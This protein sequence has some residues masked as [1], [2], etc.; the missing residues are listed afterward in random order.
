VSDS[1]D[2]LFM[3][4]CL[5]LARK[6]AGRTSPNPMVGCVIARDGAAVAAGLHTAFGKPHA[7]VVALESAGPAARGATLYTNLEPCTHTGQTPP[8]TDAIQRAGIAKV[9]FGSRDPNPAAAKGAEKLKAAGIDAVGPVLEREC[10]DLNAPFFKWIVLKT[11]FITAKWAQ[12][13][14]GKIATRI[15]DSMYISS[16]ESREEAH[17]MRN[18][19]DA[20]LVGSG[21]I[22]ADN[23][24]LTCRIEGGRD[25]IRVVTDRLAIT[26][27]EARIF[28]VGKSK[29]WIAVTDKAPALRVETLKRAGAEIFRIPD[30]E[31]HSDLKVLMATLGARGVTS[32][33]MEGGGGIMA[34][35]FEAEIVDKVVIYVA[36]KIIGGERAPGPVGGAGIQ[37]LA[38]A[39]QLRDMRCRQ[40]GPD[41]RIEARVGELAWEKRV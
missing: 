35:G 32:V 41:V 11:P 19:A 13:I 5:D 38:E 22:L 10:L 27:P 25:P 14:D 7:E 34:G 28:T 39:R 4:Q 26:P 1:A 2:E 23:P 17:A 21:T 8:C 31:G 9:V 6:G 20:V 24:Q 12:S 30:R 40:I 29:V 37:T 15:N 3:R 16:K 36:P 33:L 18:A